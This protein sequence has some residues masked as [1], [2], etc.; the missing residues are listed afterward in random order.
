MFTVRSLRPGLAVPAACA[1][2][3]GCASLD[4][5][6]CRVA[7]WRTIGYEDGASG[8]SASRIGEHREACAEYGIRP[9]MAA[10]QQGRDE[11]L[12]EYCRAEN[13]YRLGRSGSGYPALCPA[14]LE[15]AFRES[16]DAGRLIYRATATVRS[17]QSKLQR[18]ERELASVRSSLTSKTSELVSPSTNT[19]R[20]VALVVETRELAHQQGVIETEISELRL[21]LERQRDELASLEAMQ[22]Y[23]R[24]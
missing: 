5:D 20:R 11:G 4:E 3:I 2:L 15:L 9:N 1:L 18:K 24:P 8:K 13:G 23:H 6:E 19:E 21:D 12:R 22:T 7:D 16:Y 14:D 17:T 10:Y